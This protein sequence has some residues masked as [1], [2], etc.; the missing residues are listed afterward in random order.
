MAEDLSS[1]EGC[2]LPNQIKGSFQGG[3]VSMGFCPDMDLKTI[4]LIE[5]KLL[6]HQTKTSTLHTYLIWTLNMYCEV[7]FQDSRTTTSHKSVEVNHCTS[8]VNRL[9]NGETDGPTEGIVIALS[10]FCWLGANKYGDIRKWAKQKC[11]PIYKIKYINIKS[12]IYRKGS[13]LIF[14]IP[15]KLTLTCYLQL[16]IN[17]SKINIGFE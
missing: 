15:L 10:Q 16:W 13:C 6:I 7:S 14:S 2:E 9:T 3:G 17:L 11:N 5:L 4:W 12:S 1:G 8:N